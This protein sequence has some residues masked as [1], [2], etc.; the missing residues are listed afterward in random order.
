MSSFVKI[1]FRIGKLIDPLTGKLPNAYYYA[2]TNSSFRQIRMLCNLSNLEIQNTSGRDSA[3]TSC[4]TGI[5]S[6]ATPFEGFN[7][8]V[9]L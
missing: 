2:A 9:F 6:R 5:K 3:E 1:V 7:F 8:I 4:V